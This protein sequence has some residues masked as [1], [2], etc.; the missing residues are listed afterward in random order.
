VIIGVLYIFKILP[1][2]IFVLEWSGT[3]Y[4]NGGGFV[5]CVWCS[6]REGW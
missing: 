6:G 1:G 2:S 3:T 4:L 5:S